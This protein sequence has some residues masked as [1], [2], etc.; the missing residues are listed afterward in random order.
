MNL[1]PKLS[2]FDRLGV[3]VVMTLGTFIGSGVG[4][5]S[6]TTLAPVFLFLCP[7]LLAGAGVDASFGFAAG[8]IS[9]GIANG[10]AYGL[11]LYGWDRAA[12]ALVHRFSKGP[13]G[14]VVCSPHGPDRR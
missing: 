1:T 8:L 14:A 10:A 9:C 6:D 2:T 13:N 3:A 12:N 11:I 7:G 4:L 5:A